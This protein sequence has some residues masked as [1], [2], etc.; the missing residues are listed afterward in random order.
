MGCCATFGCSVSNGM[1]AYTQGS[2]VCLSA[3]PGSALPMHMDRATFNHLPFVQSLMSPKFWYKSVNFGA[4][5]WLDTQ[6][7][8]NN[9]IFFRQ[10]KGN[11]LLHRHTYLLTYL[12]YWLTTTD[13]YCVQQL[14]M[15]NAT[16][17]AHYVPR[18]ITMSSVHDWYKYLQWLMHNT[19]ASITFKQ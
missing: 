15:C 10:C 12:A 19:V 6:T 13:Y 18:V 2:K 3:S 9:K 4:V 11:E 8:I 14:C 5:L 1:W 16:C 17:T 7:D